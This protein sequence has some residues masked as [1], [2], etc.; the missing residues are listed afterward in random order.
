MF[1]STNTFRLVPRP[2][3]VTSSY[4]HIVVDVEGNPHLPL[5]RFYDKVNQWLSQGTA[6]AYLNSLLPFFTYIATDAWRKQRG[7]RWDIPSRGYPA[8]RSGLP[9]VSTGLP[10]PANGDMCTG[11]SHRPESEH[12]TYFFSCPQAILHYHAPGRTI[13]LLPS[14]A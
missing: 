13:C 11:L 1:R 7:D 14:I 10:G 8:M 6:R 3:G 2:E 5:T 9:H 4:L 12:G